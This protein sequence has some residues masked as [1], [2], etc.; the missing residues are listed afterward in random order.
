MNNATR[1]S[2]ILVII[3]ILF[4]F[5]ACTNADSLA[6]TAN[7]PTST[8]KPIPS[9]TPTPT[10]IPTPTPAP[11]ARPLREEPLEQDGYYINDL[12]G[13][14]IQFPLDWKVLSNS[15]AEPELLGIVNE[16]VGVLVYLFT[17]LLDE[18][19]TVE[20][21]SLELITELVGQLGTEVTDEPLIEPDYPL[22]ETLSVWRG[23]QQIEYNGFPLTMEVLSVERGNRM[24]S[25][26]SIGSII[27]LAGVIDD[28]DLMWS[29]WALTPPA[30][31]GVDRENAFFLSGGEPL[32]L[33]PALHQ[34]SADT[35]I[36]D[37]YSGLVRL[38]SNLQ[39]IPD[40]AERWEISDDYTVYT[41]YLRKNVSFHNGKPFTAQ[42][43]AYSW[44]RAANPETDSPTVGTYMTDII[45]VQAVIDGEA[46]EI[47]GLR[48][49]DDY[50]IEV[51]IDAPKVY[52]LSKL[53]YPT[54]WIVDKETI[55]DIETQPN[56]TGPFKLAK[57]VENEI[58][59]LSRNENYHLGF[60]SLEYLVYLLYQGPSIRLY[61]GGL[62][63][64]T[65]I[66]DD[67]L[68][69]AEDSND[70]LYGQVQPIND[71]CTTY[72]T[73]NPS[74]PPFDDP[75]VR[76]AFALAIDNERYNE[77]IYEGKGVLAN[78]LFPP[79]LPGYSPDVT[80]LGYDPVLAVQA[81][82]KS[83]YGS[84]DALP[85]IILTTQGLGGGLGTSD[86][87]II[88]MWQ[89]VLG[90]T[91]SVDQI[92]PYEYLDEVQKGN[93]GQV[94]TGG[95]CADYPDPENFADVLFHTGHPMNYNH[96]SNP[97]VDAL[98]EQAR[99][100]QDIEKRL[101]LYRQ[102]EQML[103][104]DVAAIFLLHGAPTYYVIKAY[105][106]GYISTPIGVAQSMN[107]WIERQE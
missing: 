34:G 4:A 95:W 94:L 60:V 86:A 84:A 89:E 70:P 23:Y 27:G 79:G 38:D 71:L 30:P 87:L 41:F 64:R 72:I 47:S 22:N 44:N 5:S 69:R 43:V 25:L 65:V 20:S 1:L 9:A 29:T 102:V 82:A 99:Q 54:S 50:T 42:D 62:I 58:Y 3:V 52:F 57:H 19:Q 32:T 24:F 83:T 91:I 12:Y 74:I 28:L 49:I 40:L 35:I 90:V 106:H 80:P 67:L 92:D 33:D 8:D 96:F 88:Q 107:L 77:V 21:F 76:Q 68:E 15:Q 2:L 61:E 55:D 66:D 85:E 75:L 13:I 31:Y 48:V 93:H 10:A 11:T 39:P 81:L 97:Q 16:D 100:E 36:G 6:Q 45:G 104:D 17:F 63:D 46:E 105:V 59:I 14:T 51:S 103:I 101:E 26:I 37:L 53:S 56:G 73:L 98:L 18:G 7:T 78:G